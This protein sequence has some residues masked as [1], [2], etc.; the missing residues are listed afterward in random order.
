M[1]TL[2]KVCLVAVFATGSLVCAQKNEV[3]LYVDDFTTGLLAGGA[4]AIAV[5]FLRNSVLPNAD[6]LN[7]FSNFGICR[8]RL[9]GH[10]TIVLAMAG[11][12]AHDIVQKKKDVIA[13]RKLL[14]RIAGVFVGVN[15]ALY[16]KKLA[17]QYVK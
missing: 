1:N 13:L 8:D 5:D 10:A 12:T 9:S 15:V 7:L 6:K 2:Y 16:A 17:L 3:Q 14:A 4:S 11:L